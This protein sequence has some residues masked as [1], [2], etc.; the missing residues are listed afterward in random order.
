MSAL[1]GSVDLRA[2]A[3]TPDGA[4]QKSTRVRARTPLGRARARAIATDV[5]YAA[6][7]ADLGILGTLA[8]AADRARVLRTRRAVERAWRALARLLLA[9]ITP[10]P[11]AGPGLHNVEGG[12][13]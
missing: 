9:P 13:R 1:R 7:N 3:V 5:A 11:A 10:A 2:G 4:P 12:K 8:T 6:A